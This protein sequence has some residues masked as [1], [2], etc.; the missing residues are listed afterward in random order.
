VFE[1]TL[2]R[3]REKIRTLQYVMTVHAEEEMGNDGL[4][5]FDI[6]QCILTGKIVERQRDVK[7]FEWKYLV[8]GQSVLG[9]WVVVAAKLSATDKLVIITVYEE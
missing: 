8:R 2:R 9:E 5:I 3:F 6:E 4:T 7:T 1:Q